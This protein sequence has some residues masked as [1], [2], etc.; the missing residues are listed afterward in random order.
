MT[1]RP[2]KWFRR[3]EEGSLSVETVFA[4][5]MLVWAITATFVF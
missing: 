5:P 4:I 3:S 1:L 2:N